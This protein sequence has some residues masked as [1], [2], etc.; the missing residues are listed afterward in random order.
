[1]LNF[2][3]SFDQYETNLVEREGML[4][5]SESISSFRTQ[6]NESHNE[7]DDRWIVI[8]P[9]D[10]T[11]SNELID[12]IKNNDTTRVDGL[13]FVTSQLISTNQSYSEP[14]IISEC[15]PNTEYEFNQYAYNYNNLQP[16]TQYKAKYTH[17]FIENCWVLSPVKPTYYTYAC[18]WALIGIAFAVKLY[19]SPAMERFPL[20]K[21]LLAIPAMKTCECALEGGYLAM[22]PWYSVTSNAIQYVSMARISVYTITYTVLLSFL[23]LVCKGWQTTI[24]QLDRQQA[25]NLTMI[26]GG[27]YLTYSAY[28][29]SE[30]FTKLYITMNFVMVGIY[31]F[32][33]A[34]FVKNCKSNITICTTYI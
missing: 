31:F 7:T 15:T 28:F 34:S 32:I 17:H 24:S 30:D 6:C 4:C 25:T 3:S 8:H 22:C 27:V 13:I 5:Y 21:A 12:D 14:A 23:F 19:L 29:L 11:Y 2:L 20:Q 26:M 9:F 33:G 18:L 1:M 16:Q 10:A